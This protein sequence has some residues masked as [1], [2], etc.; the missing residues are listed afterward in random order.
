MKTSTLFAVAFAVCACAPLMAQQVDASAR[1]NVSGSVARSSVSD[2][3]G[4]SAHASGTAH[5]ESINGSAQSSAM[6]STR[7][8]RISAASGTSTASSTGLTASLTEVPAQLVGKL[9]SKTAKVGERVVAKTTR[10]VRTVD[11][12]VIPK[13][14]RLVGQV[15]SVE[16]HSKAN[17]NSALSIAF[18]RAE[19]KDGQSLDIRSEI[20]SVAPSVSAME[21]ASMQ[22]DDMFAGDGGMSG[23]AMGG[24]RMLGGARAGGGGLM[25]GSLHTASFASSGV[26]S[27]AGNLGAMTGETARGA[28]HLTGDATAMGRNVRATGGL[29]G[30]GTARAM[31]YPTGIRGVMLSGDASGRTAGTLT[32]EHQNVHLDSGTQMDIG[33]APMN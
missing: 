2:S 32:A 26:R 9:D 29:A 13:G 27:S 10:T 3:A 20:R 8:S 24:G 7:N 6:T 12:T 14:T 18:D 19:L 16:A 28:G 22:N 11:G 15:T 25:G 1:Q 21:A 5:P 30:E 4:A 33:V 23:P 31:A 17:A